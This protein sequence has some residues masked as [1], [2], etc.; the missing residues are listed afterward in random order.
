MRVSNYSPPRADIKTKVY[1]KFKGV[2]FSTDPSLV[3]DSRSPYAPNL[4]SDLGGMPEKRLGWRTILTFLD[5]DDEPLPINGLYYGLING[6]NYY[7]V[8]AGTNVYSVTETSGVW[9][10]TLKYSTAANAK[11]TGFYMNDSLYILDGTNYLSFDGTTVAPV[12]GYIPRTIVGRLPAGATVS[13]PAGGGKSDYAVNL[14]TGTRM[15]TFLGD[16]SS[17]D[18]YVF[19]QSIESVDKVEYMDSG[20]DWVTAV[21]TTDYTVDLTAGKVSFLAAKDP[22]IAD[23]DNVRITYTKTT[24]GYADRIKKCTVCTLFGV[25]ATDVVFVTGN[26]DYP[27]YDWWSEGRLTLHISRIIAMRL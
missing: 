5:V 16:A 22:P 17:L 26:P 2:D 10:K 6:T 14:L 13:D 18:Y 11:S 15:E 7:L 8:H 27:A 3:N 4:V 19:N 1:N 25:N 12:V 24:T 20:A 23:T 9:S 21:I